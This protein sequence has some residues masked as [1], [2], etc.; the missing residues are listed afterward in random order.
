MPKLLKTADIVVLSS[1]YEGLSLSSIEAMASGKPF[2]ASNVQGLT[3]LVKEAGV[4]FQDNDDRTLASEL[5]KL[6]EDPD[7]A[8]Q[9]SKRCLE[10]ASQ[11]DVHKM[12]KAHLDLYKTI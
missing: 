2:V 5:S 7:Y 12:V 10:R 9:V 1:H 8:A 3:E 4:L 6:M 11:Y